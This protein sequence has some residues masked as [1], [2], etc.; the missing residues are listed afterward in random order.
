MSRFQYSR[1][2]DYFGR[3]FPDIHCV[4]GE[5]SGKFFERRRVIEKRSRYFLLF[6]GDFS[7]KPVYGPSKNQNHRDVR[8]KHKNGGYDKKSYQVWSQCVSVE[9]QPRDA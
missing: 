6:K 9:F 2:R 5:S 7:D 4:L 3:F 1:Y 8:T